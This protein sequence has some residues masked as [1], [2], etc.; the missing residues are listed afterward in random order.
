M[1]A[2]ENSINRIAVR[3]DGVT[4]DAC[5]CGQVIGYVTS[6]TFILRQADGTT[7]YAVDRLVRYATPDEEIAYWKARALAAEGVSP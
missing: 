6:P 2:F 1:I 5:E 3:V 7:T 4:N